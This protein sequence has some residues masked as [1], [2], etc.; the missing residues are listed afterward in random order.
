MAQDPCASVLIQL[1]T[2]STQG[3]RKS[4]TLSIV[5]AGGDGNCGCCSCSRLR[6][7]SC[8]RR[9]CF[10]SRRRCR[11]MSCAPSPSF[12]FS[13]LLAVPS[14]ATVA[15]AAALS[16]STSGAAAAAD[17]CMGMPG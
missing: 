8:R 14:A 17:V 13:A 11:L 1:Q 6:A 9:C 7:F 16:V 2:D 12:S 5:P 10:A 3:L 15:P 4:C